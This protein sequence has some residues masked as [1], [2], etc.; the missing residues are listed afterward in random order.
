METNPNTFIGN[1]IGTLMDDMKRIISVT[2]VGHLANDGLVLMLPLL[3]P[4]IRR[5]F[6]LTYIQTGILAGSLVLTLGAGEILTGFISDFARVKWPFLSLG[7]IILSLSLL[8]MSFCSSYPCLVVF[9]LSAG[10]GASFY[11]PCGIA[12][13]AKSMKKKIKGKV[14][15]IHGVAGCIG[16]VVFPILAGIILEKWDWEHALLFLAPVGLGGAFLFSFIK[17]EGSFRAERKRSTL[18]HKDSVLLII[19]FGCIAMFFRGLV[20]FLPVQLE[21]TGYPAASVAAVVTIFYGTGAIGELSSGFLSD[22]YSKKRILFISFLAASFLVLI[23]FRSVWIFVFPLGFFAFWVWVP[24]TALYVERA[25]E[26]RYGTA[27]G[28]LQGFGGLMAFS[29]PI[30]MGVIAEQRGISASFVFLSAIALTGSLLSLR[31]KSA[32]LQRAVT[33]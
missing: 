21:E 17:E 12:L 6:D 20:T 23:L 16:I 32:D 25:P 4:F 7:L 33:P 29:S 3:L 30:I 2:F 8:A 22:V 19:L 26:E 9:N 1:Q 24:V 10:L 18:L 11:H 14:L 5:D 31:I 15:G 27:L 13:L 28:L